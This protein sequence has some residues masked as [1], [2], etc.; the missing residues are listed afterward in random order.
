MKRAFVFRLMTA[1]TALCALSF[2]FMGGTAQAGQA[3]ADAPYAHQDYL[4]A[5]HST[6]AAGSGGS[7]QC[8]KATSQ[9][10]GNWVCPAAPSASTPMK[11]A[12]T[13]YC[14]PIICWYKYDQKSADV[15]GSD[16]WGYGGTQLGNVDVYAGFQ[17]QGAQTVSYPVQYRNSGDTTNVVFTGDLLNAA[18]GVEGT[19]VSGKFSLYNAGNV[20]AG[21]MATWDPNGYK[22]YDNTMW[23]HSQVHEWTWN[24]PG[25]P[26]SWYIYAKSTCTH[27]FDQINY[28]FYAVDQLPANPDGNGWNP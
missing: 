26:G 12:Y 13:N 22:S 2:T 25:Y 3:G 1:A 24:A 21:T 16:Y 10:V 17:L 11:A 18:P 27:T 7:D 20:P 28:E 19:Q 23:D 9:R 15:G 4:S 6:Q 5:S 14:D 8:G